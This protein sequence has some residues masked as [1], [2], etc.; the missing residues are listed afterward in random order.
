MPGDG[1]D[2]TKAYFPYAYPRS[3]YLPEALRITRQGLTDGLKGTSLGSYPFFVTPW[4]MC[5][6]YSRLFSQN[7]ALRLSLDAEAE[8]DVEPLRVDGEVEAA[9]ELA[10]SEQL[11]PGLRAVPLT[12]TARAL[13][14]LASRLDERELTLYAKT[15][16]L[17]FGGEASAIPES[18]LLALGVKRSYRTGPVLDWMRS[19]PQI[20]MYFVSEQGKHDYRLIEKVVEATLKDEHI[21]QYLQEE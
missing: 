18:Q 21:K 13:K 16:T 3:S 15:G 8:A 7:G 9:Y 2:W 17:S 12:G 5:E 20:V 14:G 11:L 1:Q 4:Q 6:M 10:L 19:A